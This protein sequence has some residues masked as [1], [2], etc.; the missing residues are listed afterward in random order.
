MAAATIAS[1]NKCLYNFRQN[2]LVAPRAFDGAIVGYSFLRMCERSLLVSFP[3]RRES[4]TWTVKFHE[5]YD[6]AKRLL[7]PRLRGDDARS[8][9]TFG[10]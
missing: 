3:L 9:K 1:L 10:A 6:I 8:G 4:S 5:F 7:G 2:S